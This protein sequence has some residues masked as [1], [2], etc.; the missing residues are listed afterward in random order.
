MGWRKGSKPEHDGNHEFSSVWQVDWEGR[1]RVSTDHP[2]SKPVELF[3]R[4]MRKH[5]RRGDICFEPFCGSGS[6]V[7]AAERLER[8]CLALEIEPLFCDVAVKRW[9]EF[10]GKKASR[11]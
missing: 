9:E 8:R 4:P 7:I 2:T 6:Q 1:A 11:A 3:A 10:T 5:T